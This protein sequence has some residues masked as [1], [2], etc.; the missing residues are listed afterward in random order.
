MSEF[1]NS[2]RWEAIHGEKYE[3][4]RTSRWIDSSRETQIFLD[5]VLPLGRIDGEK[6]LLPHQAETLQRVIYSHEIL[7][8]DPIL[9]TLATG[10]G[11]TLVMASVM[12][13]LACIKK[14]QTFIVFC[15]NTIVRDRL[16]RDFEAGSVFDEF[17]LFPPQFTE[18]R[19]ALRPSIVDGYKGLTNLLGFNLLVA[20]RHQFQQGYSGGQDHLKFVLDEGGTLGIF[21][22]EAHNTR[23]PEYKRTLDLL[24]S[25]SPFRFDVTATPDRADNLRP[26]SHEIYSL[27]VVE[28]I[29]GSYKNNR[30]IEK[31]YAKYPRLIKDVLVQRPDIK[32]YG[33]ISQAELTF[34][35]EG[36]GQVLRLRE[37]DWDDL[38]RK[39]NLKLVMDPGPMK[40]QLHLAV[41]A[42]EKKRIVA[43]GRYKPL[44]FVITPSIAGAKQAVDM[45]K[46]EFKLNPLLVV[47]DETEYEKKELREAAASLGSVD[48]PFDSVVS[49]YML[50]EGWD[51]PEVSVICLLR[52]FGSPLFA[53]QV[54]GRGLRLIRRS[55]C[56]SDRDVQELTIIDHQT[57]GLDY[58]WE[59]IDAM[60]KE[61]DQVTREREIPRDEN[62][63]VEI[64]E[65]GDKIVR[66]QIVVRQ[67]LYH[68]LLPIPDPKVIEGI[69]F[70]RALELLDQAMGCIT[71][72]KPDNLIFVEVEIEGIRRFRPQRPEEKTAR[73]LRLSAIPEIGKTQE[74]FDQ[75]KQM[76]MEW[77]QDLSQR[78][79]PFATKT[80]YL[81]SIILDHVEEG[82]GGKVPLPEMEPNILYAISLSI[83]QIRESVAYELNQRI[84]SEELL[85]NG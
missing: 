17:N 72:Y 21:N 81:Y 45:M 70:E 23:G 33:A 8:L 26:E 19:K 13:W 69:S 48:S 85:Y 32:K 22:D 7:A 77:A 50:R 46:R 28:A 18:L 52:G 47:D 24:K 9:A 78:Y 49:V 64:S 12:A 37:I 16:K 67:D 38:P 65:G 75:T 68:L 10:T 27:S 40:M 84:Y 30:H 2:K 43:N 51:V 55:G 6:R 53:N 58:L 20:N 41:E 79:D 42:I 44:L 15:P 59:E 57:L 60:I 62:G 56:E 63:N 83:P 11:K 73:G 1:L 82:L 61:G 54:L 76:I 71:D 25:K 34:R 35:D 74:L 5:H 4:W 14:I 66:E 36:S 29:T 80:N 39:K 3:K 31:G